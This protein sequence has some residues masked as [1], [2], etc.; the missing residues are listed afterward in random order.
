MRLNKYLSQAGIASRR[1]A[2]ELIARGH[3]AVNGVVTTDFSTTVGEGDVVDVN[4]R[5]VKPV[6]QYSY[7]ALHK[8]VGYV[9]T[10]ADFHDNERS[11][12]EL[13]P[14]FVSAGVKPVGRLDKDSTGLLILTDD[15]DMAY[16][17][18]H[19]SIQHEKEY[20][21]TSSSALSDMAL[22]QLR[23]GV[24]LEEGK[25]APADV[26]RISPK[27]FRIIIK[28]GWKRQIRRM[29]SAVGGNVLSLERVRVSKLSLDALRLPVGEVVQVRKEDIV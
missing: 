18:T 23:V 28:Q 9:T 7:F 16:A 6:S 17:L 20:I 29:T 5:V 13:L 19:P 22:E 21:V 3:V 26:T 12:M 27:Q 1:K 24:T 4:G 14:R 15:G 10:T 2:D 11:V 8:P 25:T